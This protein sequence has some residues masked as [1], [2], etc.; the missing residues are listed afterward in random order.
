[1]DKVSDLPKSGLP[2]ESFRPT[3]RPPM[4]RFT[5]FDD[6]STQGET[7][8]LRNSVT[9]IGRR[10][11]DINVPHD[12]MI[13]DQHLSIHLESKD[14]IYRWV[15]KDL[16]SAT[17]LWVRVRRIDLRD[18]TEFLLGGQRFEFEEGLALDENERS[19]MLSR[20]TN[21]SYSGSSSV[22]GNSFARLIRSAFSPAI[23]KRENTLSVST[24]SSRILTLI[25]GEYWI[26]R[27]PESSMQVPDDPFLASQHACIAM[28][29]D[30]TWIART[31]GVPNGMWVRMKQIVV[32]ESCSFQIGE[33]RCRFVCTWS[34]EEM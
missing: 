20:I 4:A 2:I 16:N 14:G 13:S 11:C 21:G 7:F 19:A 33:Q 17:G 8:R 25:E 22:P 31:A 24:D 9:I 32:N 3:Y 28:E 23:V 15:I 18:G 27:G 30:R 29:S 26:G 12:E 34:R 1:M 5:L 10:D 6:G